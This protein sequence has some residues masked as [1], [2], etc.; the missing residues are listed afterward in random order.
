VIFV[1]NTI[2]M[3]NP[4]TSAKKMVDLCRGCFC[5]RMSLTKNWHST[6]TMA[7]YKRDILFK[8]VHHNNHDPEH[9]FYFFLTTFSFLNYYVVT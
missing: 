3:G 6:H 5:L 8:N 7:R 1:C 4:F 2:R 9:Y